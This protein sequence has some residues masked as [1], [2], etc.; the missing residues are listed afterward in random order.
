[1]LKIIKRE[2]HGSRILRHRRRCAVTT[3]GILVVLSLAASLTGCRA[4]RKEQVTLTFLDPEWS[5]ESNVRRSFSDELLQEFTRQSGIR[6]THLPSPETAPAQ[7][8]LAQQLLRR[9][10]V[11]PDVYGIDVIWPGILGEYLVDLKPYFASELGSQDAE[12]VANNTVKGRLV[13]MPYHNNTGAL[14]Y[15]VDLLKKYGYRAPP[16]TWDEL[17]KMSIRIQEGERAKG[18]KDFWGFVWPAA[19]SEG[20]TCDGL[21]WQVAEGGGRIIEANGKISVN[22]RD[23]IRSWERAAHWVGWISSPAVLSYQ[24]W[25]AENAFWTSG[26]AAFFRGW[27]SDYFLSHPIGFALA[28]KTG[29]TSIPAGKVARAGAFGGLGLAVS[30]SSAHQAEAVEFVRFLVHKEAQLEEARVRQ[31][32]P[33]EPAL[34]GVPTMLKAYLTVAAPGQRP[35]SSLVPRPSTVTGEKYAE[36]SKAYFRSVYSVIEGKVKAPA[37]AAA[38]EKEL[39][40]I[41]GLETGKP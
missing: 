26:T 39:V 22:N 10:A 4:A 23:A 17:E 9:G 34:Y 5:H 33:K 32:A 37:A 35:G 41:T 15:R 3:A 36:V 2:K 8:A 13:A 38:L 40:G 25:D 30:R 19:A 31:G 27:I 21:E 20:L 24:E 1:V 12:L 7:L 11:S 6:V 16:E 18:M 28:D 14:F 29:L